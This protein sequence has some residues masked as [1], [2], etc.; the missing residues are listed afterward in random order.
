[1]R[2]DRLHLFPLISISLLFSTL[3]YG[4]AWSGILAPARA[5]DWTQAGI[6][7]GIPSSTWVNCVTTQCNTLFGGTVTALSISDA[8]ASAPNN[9]VVRIP[10]GSFTLSGNT[11]SNRSNVVLRGA[12]PTQTTLTLASGHNIMMGTAG[13]SGM[14]RVPSNLGSTSWTGGLTRGSTVLTLASTA[15]VSAG[16]NIVLD[17]YNNPAWVNTLGNEG[18][19]SSANSCGR[20]DNPLGFGGSDTRAQEE[21]VHVVSVDSGTQITIAAPGVAYDHT[22]GLAPQAFYWSGGNIQHDGI[23]NMSVNANGNDFSLSFP[24]CDY[25]W[26]KNVAITNIARSGV[27]FFWGYRD[28]VRDSYIAST[29]QTGGPT[30]YGIE[31]LQATFPKIENNILFGVT[32]PLLPESSYGVVAGYNYVLNTAPLAQFNS[33]EA[34]LGHNFLHLYEGNSTYGIGYDDIWGSSSQNTTFRNYI[35]GHSPNKTNYRLAIQISAHNH[36]MNVVGNV[37]GDPTY[38]TQYVCDLANQ[39]SSDVYEYDLGFSNNCQVGTAGYDTVTVSSLMRWGNWDAVTWKAN[40][41]TNGIRYCTGSGAGNAACTASETGSTDPTFPG[42]ASPSATLPASFYLA[43]K[44]SW[45]GSVNWPPIGPNVTCTTNCIA[46]AASHAAMIPAQLCYNSTAKS[47]S[48]FLTA[49]DATA[50]YA[51]GPSSNNGPTPPAGLSALVR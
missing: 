23:E 34:H 14:G 45:F 4:Q 32:A 27:F 13:Q 21:I 8:L 48:G 17:Q 18:E 7:G 19:C 15:G 25:C 46:N 31:L 50:C 36:A 10:A 38:H 5:T 40:G 47:A 51:N 37:L 39:L 44:P 16:Q 30:Q 3:S 28:E 2:R 33:F 41:N 9:T 6:P 26:V 24:F 1:M 22:A 20:N 29:N 43:A 49:F 42:L 12:G 35:S 11:Y